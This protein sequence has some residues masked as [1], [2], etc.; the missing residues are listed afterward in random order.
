MYANCIP[1]VYL[2]FDNKMTNIEMT[3][4]N[5]K[6]EHFFDYVNFH[7]QHISAIPVYIFFS[8]IFS[9]LKYAL[10]KGTVHKH[11]SGG[12]I[13]NRALWKNF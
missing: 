1:P 2:M 9:I 3:K 6:K 10:Y 11:L 8:Y 12:M 4:A 7:T 5:F 13:Q